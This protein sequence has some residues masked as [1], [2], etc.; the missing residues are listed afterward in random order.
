LV[1]DKEAAA[2]EPPADVDIVP[3]AAADDP[4][5]PEPELRKDLVK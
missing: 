4:V 1:R 2:A 3:P 5:V